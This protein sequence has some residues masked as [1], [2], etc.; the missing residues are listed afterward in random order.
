MDGVLDS[1]KVELNW[2]VIEHWPAN[3]ASEMRLLTLEAGVPGAVLASTSVRSIST[4]QTASDNYAF[5]T[6]DFSAFNQHFNVGDTLAFEIVSG[7]AVQL[8]ENTYLG[9]N[10]FF[11]AGAVQNPRRRWYSN[12][13]NDWGFQTYVT[14]VPLPAAAL[15]LFSGLLSLGVIRR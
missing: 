8:Y 9:G 12:A 15:L 3:I 1:I 10:D 6:F 11:L 13:E 4:L 5:G 7:G 2:G 14:P